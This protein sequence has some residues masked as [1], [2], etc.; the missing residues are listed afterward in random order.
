MISMEKR[1]T[2]HNSVMITS[3]KP[4]IPMSDESSHAW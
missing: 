3:A 4:T 2:I 1:Q